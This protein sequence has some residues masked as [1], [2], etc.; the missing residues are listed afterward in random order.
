METVSIGYEQED[1]TSLESVQLVGYDGRLD[2]K[3]R[4]V[5]SNLIV[6]A[7]VWS[8]SERL[9]CL[10][11]M[12]SLGFT[13]ELTNTLR[14]IVAETLDIK[15]TDVMICFSHTHSA[16]N[17]LI[18]DQ[19]FKLVCQRTVKSVKKA[20]KNLV[21]VE[22]AWGLGESSIGFNRRR[23]SESLDK[24]IGILKICD[25]DTKITRLLLLR[26][27]AHCNV[28]SPDNYSISSDFF[29]AA[30]DL[31]EKKYKCH[32][33]IIQG[34]AGDVRPAFRQD[35]A[36]FLQVH[37]NSVPVNYPDENVQKKY[38]SQ[39]MKALDRMAT[40]IYH[41]IKEKVD[42]LKPEK[43]YSI[44]MFSLQ[45]EFHADVPT[46]EKAKVIVHE[47]FTNGGISG[48][49]WFK[50]VNK[51]NGRG[52]HTQ[53]SHIEIQYFVVN[54]GCLSGI[55]NEVMSEI[56]TNIAEKANN[57]LFFFNGYTNGCSSYLPTAAEYDKGGYE[58][59]WSNLLY[60]KYHGRL[61]SFNRNTAAILENTVVSH[62]KHYMDHSNKIKDRS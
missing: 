17:A 29:G 23:N 34:A 2:N 27:T 28:L 62:W 43:I 13:E 38:F 42:Q 21:P 19:Y 48:E 8:Y 36:D 58:V 49:N 16:P 31:L 46:L 41:S 59:V 4:G 51:L 14:T 11:A 40:S 55:S 47:A 61:M 3:S 45:K 25:A 9:Y 57:Q 12:D 26:V 30:R 60:Y 15:S 22:A 52:I 5:L 37:S 39:S 20:L 18:E 44:A 50:E 7:T 56:S 53:T 6:Q 10:I 54:Q 35:N 1:I 33:I 24:R 32:V